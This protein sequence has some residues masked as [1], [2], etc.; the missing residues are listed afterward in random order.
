MTGFLRCSDISWAICKQSR[1]ITHQHLIARQH[2]SPTRGGN[3]TAPHQPGQ[4]CTECAKLIRELTSN[5]QL[6]AQHG[7]TEMIATNMR[8]P[9][10]QQVQ[11][12]AGAMPWLTTTLLH[13][14]NGLFSWTTWVSRYQKGN[15]SLDFNEARD[16][17]VWGGSGISWTICKQNANN[18]SRQIATTTPHHS[19]FTG[20]M[21]FLAPKLD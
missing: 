7:Q 2:Q 1:Q 11:F 9:A 5:R 17:G 4:V 6:P 21:L 16:D 19:I 8:R 12:T 14:F 18:R 13:P 10:H 20:R 3:D 15:T